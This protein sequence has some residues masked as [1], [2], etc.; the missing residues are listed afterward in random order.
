MDCMQRSNRR[1]TQPPRGRHGTVQAILRPVPRT[2]SDSLPSPA[3]Y[4]HLQAQVVMDGDTAKFALREST[5]CLLLR[6]VRGLPPPCWPTPQAPTPQDAA[7]QSLRSPA[8]IVRMYRM[9]INRTL[10]KTF[11][12]TSRKPSP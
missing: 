3:F 4:T 1:R 12:T 8:V 2:P 11:Q 6:F 7:L 5:C 9:S 10:N